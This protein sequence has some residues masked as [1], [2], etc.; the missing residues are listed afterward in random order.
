MPYGRLTGGWASLNAQK[1]NAKRRG[2]KL[3]SRQIDLSPGRAVYK[4]QPAVSERVSSNIAYTH[5]S[6]SPYIV[7]RPASMLLTNPTGVALS[8]VLLFEVALWDEDAAQ[9][10]RLHLWA[11]NAA[12][13]H[14]RAADLAPYVVVGYTPLAYRR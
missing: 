9:G 1:G 2:A 4:L 10:F 14:E 3:P 13:L 8:N 6:G 5:D 7:E 12:H 11:R